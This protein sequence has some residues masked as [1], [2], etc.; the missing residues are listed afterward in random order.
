[1]G[2]K[3]LFNKGK[4][5]IGLHAGEWELSSPTECS[6][7]RTCTRCGAE[8]HKVVHLWAEW[9][10]IAEAS[11]DELRT[12]GR[13]QVQ[14]QR[15][16]HAWGTPTYEA[17]DSCKQYHVCNRCHA[18]QPTAARHVMDQ[19]RY[20]HTDG[21]VQV[22]Q[23]SRCRA[24]GAIQ[25]VEHRWGNWQYNPASNGPARVCR[26]CGELQ[27]QSLPA[28]ADAVRGAGEATPAL[29]DEVSDESSPAV[30]QSGFERDHQR[31]HQ[32]LA[33]AD[34]DRRVEA[35]KKHVLLLGRDEFMAFFANL[36]QLRENVLA[37]KR[38]H[39]ANEGK[40]WG[41][42]IEDQI[43]YRMARLQTG[44]HDPDYL[45]QLQEFQKYLNFIEWL[46]KMSI[47]W[48]DEQVKLV[49]KLTGDRLAEIEN[50]RAV[51]KPAGPDAT[52]ILEAVREFA[53]TGQYPGGVDR[54]QKDMRA[55][56]G[57]PAGNEMMAMLK[58]MGASDGGDKTLNI[59]DY[60][61]PGEALFELQWPLG[62]TLPMAF[63]QLDRKTQFSVLFQEWTR[64]AMEGD[65]ALQQGD[66]PLRN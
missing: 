14:E 59:E 41:G 57:T 58:S 2:L 51:A 21:C 37:Q 56:A 63:D 16:N 31:T 40:A 28:N 20:L 4:C 35:V 55:I 24:D 64:R 3:D 1:M 12:C 36:K 65:Y 50:K 13:C 19:W 47:T 46:M 26:R 49:V 44:A 18:V 30:G 32:W 66:V 52:A 45:R 34:D 38:T 42:F 15:V 11:C 54:L 8:H 33:I 53:K 61:Q 17:D 7:A 10:F 6:F 62:V 25:R 48:K 9:G 60:Y 22:Q 29:I 39:E 27:T 43:A 23:C 5:L